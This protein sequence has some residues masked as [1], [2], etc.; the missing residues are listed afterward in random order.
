MSL[1]ALLGLAFDANDVIVGL[2]SWNG[3]EYYSINAKPEDGVLLTRETVRPRL[4]RLLED[5]MKLQAHIETQAVGAYG[6]VLANGG[7]KLKETTEP[8]AP[9]SAG[10]DRLRALST[11]MDVL[12]RALGTVIQQ[13][14]INET[15]AAGNYA[16]TFTYAP[17]G[18]TDLALPSIFTALEE[19]LGLKLEGGRKVPVD[20]VVIDHVEHPTRD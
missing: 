14:V 8:L 5:R 17:D 4:R 6:L 2:P 16:F 1:A 13:P 15:G 7:P 3:S 19:Q 18:A 11:T 20:R 12:A 10:R 9:I